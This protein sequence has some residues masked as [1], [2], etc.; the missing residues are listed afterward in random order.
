MHILGIGIVTLDIINLVEHYPTEDEELRALSQRI[1]LGG[2]AA[3]T[4][5]VLSQFGHACDWVGTL[6][7]DASANVILEEFSQNNIRAKYSK[8]IHSGRQP[9]SY[10]NLNQ[11]NG[12]RTIVHYRDL[13]ELDFQHFCTIPL[14]HFDWLHFEARAIHETIRMV[15]LSKKQYPNKI[16][17]IEVEKPRDDIRAILG[18]ADVYLFS[19]NY[20]NTIGFTNAADF[21]HH[22][23][24]FSPHADLV[25][26]WG[27]QGAFTLLKTGDL[28]SSN[29]YPPKQ[30]IDTLGA[31]DTFNAAIIH[32]RLAKNHWQSTLNFACQ[33]AGKKCGQMGFNKLV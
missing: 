21:L 31:G 3:N 8:I 23:K 1:C 5:G 9:T 25:V 29:A 32:H 30:V 33:L 10:I 4:L 15:K 26:A 27:N 2:N 20:A 24:Q 12:S 22:Q 11:R 18:L 28:L 7:S 19:K 17:S 6:A 14:Q 16:I 13:P